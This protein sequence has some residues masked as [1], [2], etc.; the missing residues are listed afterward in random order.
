MHTPP[1]GAA[2]RRLRVARGWSQER[3]AGDAEVSTRHLSCLETGRAS[4]SREMVL[5]L[6][7]ALD[8]PLRER[9]D[10]LHAAGFAPVYP[11][12]DYEADG[13]E[14]VRRAVDQLLAA[15]EPFGAIAVDRMWNVRRLNQGATRLLAWAMPLCDAP[16][17][18]FTN[19]LRATLHPGGL[20][21][22]VENFDEV[23]ATMIDR[24]RREHLREVDPARRR[25]FEALF[26]EA[27]PLPTTAHA[28]ATGPVLVMTLRRGDERLRVFTTITTL[29]T[30]IDVTAQET[31]IESYLAADEATARWF[32]DGA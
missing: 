22:C 2:L 27:G 14:P 26:A 8:L 30:P 20:R 23:A 18:V 32:R 13:L 21:R 5:T 28:P 25:A 4:P 1:F 10:L 29:G 15:H 19:V 9:N 17:E 11:N 7:S 12:T 3:L 16:P 24:L 6:G 31:H